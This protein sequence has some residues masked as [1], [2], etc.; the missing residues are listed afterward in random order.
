VGDEEESRGQGVNG[1]WE[2]GRKSNL[3]SYWKTNAFLIL[4]YQNFL[5]ENEGDKKITGKKL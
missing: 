2:E 1:N 5:K 3:H 4:F